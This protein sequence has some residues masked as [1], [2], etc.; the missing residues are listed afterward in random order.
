[1]QAVILIKN[2]PENQTTIQ[3]YK[4]TKENIIDKI[5]YFKDNNFKI[6]MDGVHLLDLIGRHDLAFDWCQEL[7]KKYPNEGRVWLEMGYLKSAENN[8]AS[9]E[10]S[11]QYL[12]KAIELGEDLPATYD[13]LGLIYFNL[14]QFLKAKSAW[15]Q[16]LNIDSKNQ[17]AKDYLKQ[18][19]ALN[20]P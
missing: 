5:I 11:S 8:Q 9:L 1:S 16:A 6:Q 18:Y 2:S 4:I 10:G 15:Q 17:N 13:Q 12:E 20:L 3:Q 7:N 19:E 14:G